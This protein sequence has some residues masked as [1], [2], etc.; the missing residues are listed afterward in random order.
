MT[1]PV[2]FTLVEMLVTLALLAI[3]ASA[4]LPL[5][6]VTRQRAKEAELRSALIEIRTAIDKY[7]AAADLGSIEKPTGS[8]GYPA[9][10]ESLV[11]GVKRTSSPDPSARMVFLRRVPRDPFFDD[12]A[13]S[14]DKTWN[15]RRYGAAPG[16]FSMG[17]DVFDVSSKSPLQALDG[18]RIDEW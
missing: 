10:L 17:A 6:S 13:V 1:R 8:S 14:A 15:T 16:D 11:I 5:A 18:T 2:G 12:A 9:T 4:V 7:K 3:V